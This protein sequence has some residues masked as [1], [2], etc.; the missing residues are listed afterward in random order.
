M[1]RRSIRSSEAGSITIVDH[2]VTGSAKRHQVAG[3]LR[4]H[5]RVPHARIPADDDQRRVAAIGLVERADRVA[6]ARRAVDL[7]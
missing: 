2:F 3:H 1:A 7:H 6:Q 5:G 4:F